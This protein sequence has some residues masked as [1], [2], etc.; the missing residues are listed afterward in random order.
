MCKIASQFP[1]WHREPK[2]SALW[3]FR[4]VGES[5]KRADSY[6]YLWLIHVD[7]WQKLSQCCK[8]VIFQLKLKYNF[9][10]KCN[11]K[12]FS[13][14]CSKWVIKQWRLLATSTMHL[15]QELL[16][17]SQC[18]IG[19]K[20]F[21]KETR[22]L[23]LRRVVAGYRK[24]IMTNWEDH[25]SLSSDNYVTSWWRTQ[26]QSFYGHSAFEANWKGKKLDKWVP[27][28]LTSWI[29]K[30]VILKCH[31]LLLS[32]TPMSNFLYCIVMCD[33]KVDFLQ[34]AMTN[35]VVGPKRS[36]KALPRT[37]LAPKKSHGHCLVVCWWSHLLELSKSWSNHYIWGVCSANW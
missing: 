6:V 24:L 21:A 31:L 1:V 13:Y 2:D 29:K 8:A 23:K 37:K 10:K 14:L 15:I 4:E 27:H 11:F 32:A 35:S 17:N 3:Q 18:S 16:V 20:S 19:S 36:S 9:F 25:Q 22:V 28:E 7:V 34:L 30:I 12:H 33:K 26:C 5:F